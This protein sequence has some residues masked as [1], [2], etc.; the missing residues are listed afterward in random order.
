MNYKLKNW[1]LFFSNALGSIF[2]SFMG[3]FLLNYISAP[4]DSFFPNISG[5]NH[6]FA[7]F[8]VPASF[9]LSIM[10][11]INAV[12]NFRNIFGRRK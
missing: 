4:I 10:S 5:Y 11:A 3:I 1:F 2:L 9:G 8:A 12:E 6:F 7:I